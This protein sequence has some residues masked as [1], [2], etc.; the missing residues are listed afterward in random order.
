MT[1]QLRSGRPAEVLLVEDNDNDAELTRIGFDLAGLAVNLHRVPNGEECMDFLRKQG[2]HAGAT[3]PDIVLLDL[4][5][6]RMGGHEVLLALSRDE[7][8]N[9][10]PVVVL[11]TSAAQGD[12]LK[13]YKL[14]C[15]SYVVKQMDFTQF[16]AE[17]KGIVDYWF[18]LVALPP[19]AKS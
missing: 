11:S 7:R 4:N 1:T 5:M 2:M 12:I 18:G 16:S 3:A 17:I 6:P 10:L 15:R 9:H 8:L 14:G 13:S 19:Q